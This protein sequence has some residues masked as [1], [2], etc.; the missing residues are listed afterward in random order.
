[1]R[2]NICFEKLNTSHSIILHTKTAYK[3][4]V[5]TVFNKS[6]CPGVINFASR[7]KKIYRAA[8]DDDPFAIFF[9]MKIYD[10]ILKVKSKLAEFNA[11]C[12]DIIKALEAKGINIKVVRN[13][14]PR[15]V[16]LNFCVP[17]CYMVGYL[18]KDYDRLARLV[19]GMDSAGV[20]LWDDSN[21]ILYEARKAIRQVMSLAWRWH[22]TSVTR[23][24][25]LDHESDPGAQEAISLMGE[26]PDNILKKE[27]VIPFFGNQH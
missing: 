8:K 18:V 16:S 15:R 5:G 3:L 11:K 1:M 25:L 17:Y 2:S 26:I 19:M 20:N 12:Q 7:L 14:N 13:E 23:E 27:V 6:R 10:A 21:N 4:F 24:R 9:L 22:Q